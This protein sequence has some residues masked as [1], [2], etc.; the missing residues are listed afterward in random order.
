MSVYIKEKPEFVEEALKSVLENQTVLPSELIMVEDGPVTLEL[1]AVL[2]SYQD[3]YPNIMKICPL[4]KNVGLGKALNYGLEQCSY[5]LVMRMDADDVCVNNRFEIQLEFMKNN[6][7]V[8]VV[9]GFIGEFEQN[10]TDGY[11]LKKM[12]C[13]KDDVYNYAK[14]R[15]PINHMTACFRKS[16]IIAAGSY[17][18]LDYLED[19]YLWSRLL[20]A[21]KTIQN[22]PKILV[23]ARI[24]NGFHERRGNKKIIKGWKV[25]QKYLND[26]GMINK[27]EKLRNLLSMHFMCYMP[28][29]LRRFVYNKILRKK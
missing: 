6:K 3:K 9:G 28:T 12:P 29:N 15:N 14:L 5:E 20:V 19:Q 7:D 26:N 25:L 24:G 17:Q 22:I 4:E 10:Y 8:S 16:D 21:G 18:P 27:Y 2:K 13:T 1:E 11:R 23:Y